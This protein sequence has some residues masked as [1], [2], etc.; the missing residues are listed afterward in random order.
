MCCSVDTVHHSQG[1]NFLFRTKQFPGECGYGQDPEDHGC[2]AEPLPGVS[3]LRISFIIVSYLGYLLVS[4]L[5]NQNRSFVMP[6]FGFYCSHRSKK[7][8][9]KKPSSVLQNLNCKMEMLLFGSK[10]P[11]KCLR[12][13]ACSVWPCA[14]PLPPHTLLQRR[15]ISPLL[16]ISL[17]MYQAAWWEQHTCV[18]LISSPLTRWYNGERFH[19]F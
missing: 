16:G 13:M 8:K 9:K 4:C 14:E 19:L 6:C 5:C 2:S 11:P 1:P 15:L 12:H 10:R 18:C 7:K 17:K 3:V